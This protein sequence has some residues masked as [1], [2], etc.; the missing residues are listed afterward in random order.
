MVAVCVTSAVFEGVAC[1]EV[2][3]S[4]AAERILIVGVV[5][6]CAAASATGGV[7]IRGWEKAGDLLFVPVLVVPAASESS[8]KRR[9][10]RAR[11]LE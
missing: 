8:K 3:A 9:S 5:V 2:A 1:M 10:Y 6:E 7:D 11:E 4:D